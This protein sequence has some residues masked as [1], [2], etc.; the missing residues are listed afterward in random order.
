MAD[1]KA[2]WSEQDPVED[3]E[4]IVAR[5]LQAVVFEGKQVSRGHTYVDLL[6]EKLGYE[7]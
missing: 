3:L 7:P 4:R 1:G 2:R 6:K 5:C